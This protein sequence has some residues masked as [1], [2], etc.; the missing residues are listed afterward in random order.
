MTEGQNL[1]AAIRSGQCQALPS[2]IIPSAHALILRKAAESGCLSIIVRLPV[3]SVAGR[4]LLPIEIK[5]HYD[6]E[7]S[8]AAFID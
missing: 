1:L 3:Q 7:H 5:E 4:R 8:A 2:N 6:A